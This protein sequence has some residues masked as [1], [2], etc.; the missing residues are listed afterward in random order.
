MAAYPRY[1]IALSRFENLIIILLI[2]NSTLSVSI[3]NSEDACT[4]VYL[5]KTIK[6][7]QRRAPIVVS[8]TVF[9]LVIL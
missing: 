1:P 4:L 3:N 8:L 5:M 6:L 2:Q 7:F 9:T